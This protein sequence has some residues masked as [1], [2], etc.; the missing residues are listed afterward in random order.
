MGKI[1]NTASV[2]AFY[3]DFWLAF[4][5]EGEERARQIN[6]NSGRLLEKGKYDFPGIVHLFEH[7]VPDPP[8]VG[9]I[10]LWVCTLANQLEPWKEKIKKMHL[11]YS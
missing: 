9:D 3:A 2:N 5:P 8:D 1:A 10:K 11:E 6:Q 7:T 4:D